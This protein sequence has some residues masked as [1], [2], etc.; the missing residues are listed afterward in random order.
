[1]VEDKCAAN[2]SLAEWVF[3]DVI[4]NALDMSGTLSICA[5][6]WQGFEGALGLT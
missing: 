6:Q 2:E 3:L 4:V 1:M 5:A